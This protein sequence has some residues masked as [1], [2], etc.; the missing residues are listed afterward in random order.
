MTIG[1]RIKDARIRKGLSQEELAKAI[2]STKQ[3]IYKYENEMI[4]VVN[5]KEKIENILM[6]FNDKDIALIQDLVESKYQQKE[7]AEKYGVTQ[8]GIS[9]RIGF[10]TRKFFDYYCEKEEK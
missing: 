9:C 8:G 2:N 6:R 10:L 7:L 1:N 5:T 3:A 4:E